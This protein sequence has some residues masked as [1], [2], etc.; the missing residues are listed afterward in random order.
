M[1]IT[2]GGVT[3]PDA[4]IWQD[5]KQEFP[6]R[7]EL[8][9]TVGG[10]MRVIAESV[11]GFRP[12]TLTANENQGW[13][14][15]ATYDALLAISIVPGAE[16]TFDFH[17]EDTLQVIFRH[18]DYPALDVRPLVPGGEDGDIFIGEIKLITVG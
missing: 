14:D 13:F 17:G 3:L 15:K 10:S 11:T 16:Y 2:L 1:A 12:I 7:Q 6:V 8:K 18:N 9:V 4:I 5:R